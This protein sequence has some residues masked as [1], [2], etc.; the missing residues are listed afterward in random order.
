MKEDYLAAYEFYKRQYPNS[1]ILFHIGEWYCAFE[2]DAYVMMVYLDGYS[3]GYSSE[4]G[5][6]WCDF[7]QSELEVM[8]NKLRNMANLPVTVVEY[9]NSQGSFDIPKVKQILQDM[10]DDY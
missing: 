5:Y 7:H 6:H 8:C 1:V 10:E 2:S 3:I 9:R 4:G